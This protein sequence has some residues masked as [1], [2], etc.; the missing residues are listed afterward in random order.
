VHVFLHFHFIFPTDLYPGPA[1]MATTVN[2]G[3][4]FESKIAMTNANMMKKP[5]L[6]LTFLLT[7]LMIPAGTL[8][9]SLVIQARDGGEQVV[10]LH[11]LQKF[12][13]TP[14]A[15]LVSPTSGSTI[16]WSLAA[17]RSI[18]FRPSA[19]GIENLISP[20]AV[21]PIFAYPNPFTDRVFLK[22]LPAGDT[23]V[24]LLR[25]DGTIVLET[26]CRPG[27]ET[28]D[29]GRLPSGTYLVRAGSQTIRLI[30]L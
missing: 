4:Q 22:N 19:S 17:I 15:L 30:K 24:R 7:G 23:P 11:D 13:F 12:T 20:A 26:V 28:I 5:P 25:F 3:A 16:T 21:V 27:R 29:S 18:R 8:A 14:D 2:R 6:L 10:P 1:D 9:Q